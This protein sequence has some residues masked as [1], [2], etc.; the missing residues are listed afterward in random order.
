MKTSVTITMTKDS[1]E[2]TIK[3][4]NET[5]ADFLHLDVMDGK[6]VPKVLFPIEEV[7]TFI[8]YNNKPLDIHLMVNDIKKYVKDYSILK[9]EYITFHYEIKEDIKEII[10]YIK[11]FNIKVGLSI[12]PN[13]KVEEI[14]KY[15]PYL[16]Q[17]LVMSVEP[18]L[19]GQKFIPHVLPKISKLKQIREENNYNYLISVDGGIN[20]EVSKLLKDADVLSVGSFVSMSDNFQVQ[21]DKLKAS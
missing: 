11:S 12:K 21:L 4:L 19:G 7:K 15:L 17:I 2:S 13:T 16:D 1:L 10:N 8:K 5:D 3:K 18:G 20:D 14:I 6:F 9:P